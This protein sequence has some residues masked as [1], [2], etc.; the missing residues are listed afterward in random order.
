[1]VCR[2]AGSPEQ[3]GQALERELTRL[4][5]GLRRAARAL[6]AAGLTGAGRTGRGAGQ[7][8]RRRSLAASSGKADRGLVGG[9]GREKAAAPAAGRLQVAL[10]GE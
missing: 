3:G 2:R 6:G 5:A 10:R 7:G 8:C 1:M 4:D 9:S